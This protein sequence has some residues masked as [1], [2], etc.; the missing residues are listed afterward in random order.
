MLDVVCKV[1]ELRCSAGHKHVLLQCPAKHGLHN[2]A[3]ADG[4]RVGR[5]AG[6]ADAQA[7]VLHLPAQLRLGRRQQVLHEIQALRGQPAHAHQIHDSILLLPLGRKA[8]HLEA[9][10]LQERP[11]GLPHHVEGDA[12]ILQGVYL[13]PCPSVTD[14]LET[15]CN[16]HVEPF[17]NEG[18][19]G[20][21]VVVRGDNLPG[22][23]HLVQELRCQDDDEVLR[24]APH[25][26]EKLVQTHQ[27]VGVDEDAVVAVPPDLHLH[28]T[29]E[30]TRGGLVVA[31]EYAVGIGGAPLAKGRDDDQRPR[32]QQGHQR[33]NERVGHH[34]R[35]VVPLRARRP[36]PRGEDPEDQND[37]DA[38]LHDVGRVRLPW[39]ETSAEAMA[40]NHRGSHEHEGEHAGVREADRDE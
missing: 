36:R 32:H 5:V 21:L 18:H 40:D 35:R 6:D 23:P 30:G 12:K 26:V 16:G 11:I 38:L 29:A 7:L 28:E 1:E 17:A 13:V 31:E 9:G 2:P 10:Q 22:A 37:P 19:H 4:L 24:R 14:V 33:R 3:S 34:P 25:R 20:N 27:A 8:R 15:L 39:P